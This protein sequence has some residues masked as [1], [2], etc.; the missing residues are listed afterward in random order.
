MTQEQIGDAVGLTSVH[1]NRTLRSLVAGGV[2]QR[3]KRFVRFEDWDRIRS[4]ADFSTLY[5]HLDQLGPS[6]T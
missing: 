1:V 5:L 3:D 4:I 6:L 2:I